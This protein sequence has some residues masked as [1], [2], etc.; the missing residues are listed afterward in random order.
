MTWLHMHF[1][2][3]VFSHILTLIQEICERKLESLK[4]TRALSSKKTATRCTPLNVQ[5]FYIKN[6]G[7]LTNVR[8][9][10]NEGRFDG[11]A[12]RRT[13]RHGVGVASA[14]ID[15]HICFYFYSQNTPW[16][17]HVY[18]SC[19]IYHNNIFERVFATIFGVGYLEVSN[20]HC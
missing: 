10:G 20:V 12:C 18:V 4:A 15:R 2:C 5:S 8:T 11:D 7:W 17:I 16:R 13:E 9:A 14:F 19:S 1:A 3:R 6:T